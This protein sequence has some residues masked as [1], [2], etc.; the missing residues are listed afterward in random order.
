MSKKQK[1]VGQKKFNDGEGTY[2]G[3]SNITEAESLHLPKIEFGR[4][5]MTDGYEKIFEYDLLPRIVEATRKKFNRAIKKIDSQDLE[6]ITR[7]IAGYIESTKRKSNDRDILKASLLNYLGDDVLVRDLESVDIEREVKIESKHFED[8][9]KYLKIN[10]ELLIK[11]KSLEIYIKNARKY[12][13]EGIER[14]IKKAEEESDHSFM[15][16]RGLGDVKYYD[17]KRSKNKPDFIST[18]KGFKDPC[19]Y[20]ENKLLNSYTLSFHVAEKFM[21]SA[22]NQRR[23]RISCDYRPMIENLFT[24]FFV[25]DLFDNGQYELLLLPNSN[26]LYIT[27]TSLHP[28]FYEFHISDRSSSLMDGQI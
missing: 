25:S 9:G 6:K 11:P 27:D 5:K 12:T 15:W 23:C 18:Y 14:F 20:F 8:I 17:R 16:Y 4:K 1:I 10:S 19:R 28:H 26:E 24:S 21:R 7:G 3:V 22:F 2:N 13:L